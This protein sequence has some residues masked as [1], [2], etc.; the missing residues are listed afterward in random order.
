MKNN[1]DLVLATN[2]SVM[3]PRSKDD[4]VPATG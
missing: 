4:A 3:S 2:D 1:T